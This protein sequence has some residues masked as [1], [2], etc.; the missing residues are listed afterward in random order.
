MMFA[1]HGKPS[2]RGTEPAPGMRD[3]LY[4]RRLGCSFESKDKDVPAG[5][6]A[7][8]DEV[9]RQGAASGND[10]EPIRHL[11]PSADR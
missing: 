11:P 8:F 9:A 5:G 6:A 7:A 2:R 4:R 3:A 1:Q 10:P